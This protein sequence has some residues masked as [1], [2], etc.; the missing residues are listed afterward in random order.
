MTRFLVLAALL[1]ST[2]AFAA[3][4]ATPRPSRAGADT[5]AGMR[6]HRDPVTGQLGAEA[7]V[8][9]S[10][11]AFE[12]PVAGPNYDTVVIEQLEDGAVAMWPT[13][14][15]FHSAA[16]ATVDANGALHEGCAQGTAHSHDHVPPE[17]R[18]ERGAEQ[19][20]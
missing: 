8:G 10:A 11:D 3:E 2:Q 15:E 13:N 9:K 7:P 18:R 5:A 19:A 16:F 1:A 12:S 4:P 20:Q 6:I 17:R 14:N